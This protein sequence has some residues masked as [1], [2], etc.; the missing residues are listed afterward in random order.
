MLG[1]FLMILFLFRK[2]WFIH[3]LWFYVIKLVELVVISRFLFLV[4]LLIL[5]HLTYLLLL[6]DGIIFILLTYYFLLSYISMIWLIFDWN[7]RSTH[8]VV[9][10]FTKVL[11]IVLFAL[12]FDGLLFLELGDWLIMAGFRFMAHE[13][14]LLFVGD[15]LFEVVIE[16]L[17]FRILLL[18]F[19]GLFLLS[20]LFFEKP[21][22]DRKF[23]M[24]RLSD[25]F[26]FIFIYVSI[27][28]R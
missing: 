21:G 10:Y 12:A 26:M 8:F 18:R 13:V 17:I 24:T 2:I 9:L 3:F 1:L 25:R 11:D 20:G 4:L 19:N 15:E 22:N 23:E 6:L 5:T 16:L 7:F 28:I 14:V 27:C